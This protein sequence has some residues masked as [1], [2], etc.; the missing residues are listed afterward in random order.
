[1]TD[2]EPLPYHLYYGGWGSRRHPP[3]FS[4]CAASVFVSS[5][6]TL[7]QCSFRAKFDPG[8]DGNPTAC[9]KHRKEKRRRATSR[10]GNG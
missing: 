2:Y 10:S 8:P 9:G 4:K 1:M 5:T 3:D 6:G 7:K